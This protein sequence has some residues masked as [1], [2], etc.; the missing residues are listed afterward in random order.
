MKTR[1]FSVRQ[2]TL[3]QNVLGSNSLQVCVCVDFPVHRL[4]ISALPVEM[5]MNY[6]TE[7]PKCESENTLNCR[8]SLL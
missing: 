2:M 7:G 5:L 3:F 4:K 1:D 8:F 6:V